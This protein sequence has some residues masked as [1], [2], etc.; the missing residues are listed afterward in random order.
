MDKF[1]FENHGEKHDKNRFLDSLSKDDIEAIHL[2]RKSLER[3]NNTICKRFKNW[4]L[5]TKRRKNR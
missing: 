2:S 4:L 1:N 3:K 5:N